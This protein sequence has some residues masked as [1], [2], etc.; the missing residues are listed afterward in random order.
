MIGSSAL[1]MMTL[2]AT[3]AI[4][5][6]TAEVDPSHRASALVGPGICDPGTELLRDGG[7]V[8]VRRCG[9]RGTVGGVGS[10]IDAASLNA[11]GLLAV[12]EQGFVC[13]VSARDPYVSN[14]A[15]GVGIKA[16]CG[17]PSISAYGMSVTSAGQNMLELAVNLAATQAQCNAGYYTPSVHGYRYPYNCVRVGQSW[18]ATG[19][20][21]SIDDSNAMAMRLVKKSS[22]TGTYCDFDP[23]QLNGVIFKA[24]LRCNGKWYEGYGSS[25]TAAAN[26]AAVQA[27]A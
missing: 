13:S 23:A 25:V 3:T 12:A 6:N 4:S 9:S 2:V 7:G 24:T 11:N 22:A 17:G 26:D 14:A 21:T 10:N 20:G 16:S 18:G 19:L 5:G 27:G 15:P 1:I 8:V